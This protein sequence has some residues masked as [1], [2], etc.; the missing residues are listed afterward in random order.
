MPFPFPGFVRPRVTKEPLEFSFQKPIIKAALTFEVIRLL[1]PLLSIPTTARTDALVPFKNRPAL[2]RG[3]CRE[4]IRLNALG[5]PMTTNY[6]LSLRVQNLISAPTALTFRRIPVRTRGPPMRLTRHDSTSP[7]TATPTPQPRLEKIEPSI[8]V[9]TVTRRNRAR[10]L[11]LANIP[12]ETEAAE[13][14]S[15]LTSRTA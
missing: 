1:P 6:S 15:H 7:M 9:E 10:A 8:R 11:D 4:Q 12:V 14:A 5:M 3:V 2:R 13:E